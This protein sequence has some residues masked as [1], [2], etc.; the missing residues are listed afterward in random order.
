MCHP[1]YPDE[2]QTP[3]PLP[4]LP[5]FLFLALEFVKKP[6]FSPKS[7]HLAAWKLLF[8]AIKKMLCISS[9]RNVT[10]CAAKRHM[11]QLTW[12]GERDSLTSGQDLQPCAAAWEACLAQTTGSAV[13]KGQWRLLSHAS[14]LVPSLPCDSVTRSFVM[15]SWG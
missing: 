10:P 9:R 5:P 1:E 13:C 6:A 8:R 3:A 14:C 2:R 15:R 4:F 11:H 7:L 12:L